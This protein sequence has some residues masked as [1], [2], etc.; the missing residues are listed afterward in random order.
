MKSFLYLLQIGFYLRVLLR[1]HPELAGLPLV[2]HSNGQVIETSQEAESRSVKPGMSLS[3]A[4]SIL[5]DEGTYHQLDPSEFQEAR[6]E[7]LDLA[8][9]VS[10]QI[11][12]ES[13]ASAWINLTGQVNPAELADRFLS[14]L[15]TNGGCQLSASLASSKWLAKTT[16]RK[17][18]ID[19]LALGIAQIEILNEEG[20]IEGLSPHDLTP[21]EPEIRERLVLMGYRQVGLIKNVSL[22]TLT[23]QFG[24]KGLLIYQVIRNQWKDSIKPTYP[25]SSWSNTLAFDGATQNRFTIDLAMKQLC[26][27]AQKELTERD[28]YAQEIVLLGEEEGGNWRSWKRKLAKPI[29]SASGLLASCNQFLIQE[30]LL[31]PIVTLRLILCHLVQATRLQRTLEGLA[32]PRERRIA[33]NTAY[34]KARETYGDSV[35]RFA[36][37]IPTERRV[38][39]LRA[40]RD[41]T[42]WV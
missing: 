8:L 7:W 26:E 38:K 40:W 15:N 12:P 3:E 41:A 19:A 14:L 11:E 35:L 31:H 2:L 22:K 28:V 24:K 21:L 42:G 34:Y 16:A 17:I 29:Q 10:D 23:E 13:P 32:D 5:R 4:Q 36:H 20:I 39:V 25:P 6:D 30:P 18:E 33:A 9:T 37:E 27:N 1:R